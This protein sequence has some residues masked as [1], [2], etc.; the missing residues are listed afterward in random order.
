MIFNCRRLIS[1]AS[2]ILPM[3]PG[4]ILFTGTPQGVILG[5]PEPPEQRHWLKP[6]D[7]VVSELEGLGQ[8]TVTLA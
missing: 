8:L 4:D 3:E 6:G 1:F 5:Q 7:K 2:G